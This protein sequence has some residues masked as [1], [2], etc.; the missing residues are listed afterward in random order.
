MRR[1]DE[2]ELLTCVVV[3]V[4]E[5]NIIK[6]HYRIAAARPTYSVNRIGL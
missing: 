4:V 6:V 2:V 3:V 5:M 1:K